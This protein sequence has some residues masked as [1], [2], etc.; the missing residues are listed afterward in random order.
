MLA[1][2]AL[3]I[4]VVIVSS[5]AYVLVV[6]ISSQQNLTSTPTPTPTLAPTNPTPKSTITPTPRPIV[7][8]TPKSAVTPAPAQ[9]S[10]T[11][12]QPAITPTPSPPPSTVTPTP[13][14]TATSTPTPTPT[15]KYSLSEAV[16]AGY[17]E[18]N[19][20]GYSGLGA[21]FGTSSGDSI[22]VNIK[23]LVSYTIEIDPIPTGTLLVTSGNAQNMAVL[24]LRGLEAGLGYY[25]RDRILLDTPTATQWLFSGYCVN[26]HKSNPTSTTIFTESG[27][28]D[29]N[30]IKIFN[31]LNQLPS[32]VTT[33][34]AIQTAVSVVT[35]NVSRN[36]LQSTWPSFVSEI[37]NA[38]TILEKAGIDIS[39]AQLFV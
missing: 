9:S 25:T 30:V 2:I 13:T 17:V 34:G 23:R 20:T 7:T 6:T 37:Q 18:A 15:P 19:I 26:F 1:A 11:P 22:I 28:A 14:P 3:I 4:I 35:D 10:P 31:I 39:N 32:N 33:N 5:G 24:K 29:A 16:A 8:P 38:R 27:S 36:E 12:V 21:I